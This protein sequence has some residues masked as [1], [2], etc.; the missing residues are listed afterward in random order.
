MYC[1]TPNPDWKEFRAKYTP[2]YW[3]TLEG[4]DSGE[5][6]Y[7]DTR[8]VVLYA[9]DDE[10]I[11][12]ERVRDCLRMLNTVYGGTNTEELDKV[13]DTPRAPWKSVLGNPNI[14][15]LPLDA[16]TLSVEYRKI[17]GTLSGSSPVDDAAQKADIIPG[18]LNIYI[19]NS[20]HGSILGQA[21]LSSN[22]AYGLYS[23][24]GGYSVKGTLPGYDLGKTIAHEVGHTL[25][26]V[27]TFQDEL[28][29][30]FSPYTDIPEQ[31][32]P[33]FTTE[34]YE[35]SP[36]VWEQK[37]DNRYK[38]R[39]N[40]TNLSCLHIQPDPD[41]APDEQGI[42]FMDYGD[43][44]VSLMFSQNQVDMMRSYLQGAENTTLTLKSA[45][46][47]SISAGGAAVESVAAASDTSSSSG[48]LS[49]GAI[50]G[51]VIGSIVGVLLLIWLAYYSSKHYGKGKSNEK[52]H[53]KKSESYAYKTFV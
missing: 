9:N 34:L 17:S 39:L 30:N 20:G 12:I 41:A 14:Q 11:N 45:D 10:K 36:G 53:T 44:D 42:N 51:I 49:T 35:S 50:I 15:F 6:L 1:H 27:H 23:T 24:I 25:S 29:D 40:G 18:V 48:G 43:D 37:D 19:G 13:P 26:L 8:W 31:V 32:R 52:E 21:E 5:T 47:V 16:S 33:N 22:I 46:A 2:E 4:K 3:K 38:D 7:I 28:C